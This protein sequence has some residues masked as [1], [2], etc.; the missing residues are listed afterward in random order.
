[1]R[2]NRPFPPI[3]KSPASEPIETPPR[4]GNLRR[5]A[6]SF[7]HRF[8]DV[9]LVAAGL[10]LAIA[11]IYIYNATRAP[12]QNLTQRDINSAVARALET[13]TPPPSFESKAFELIRPSLV[14]IQALNGS[15]TTAKESH[16][17]G[18]VID[19]SGGILT[20]YHVVDDATKITVVF[21]DGSQ[22]EAHVIAA[23]PE[24]DLALI[25]PEII[26]DD[27]LPA[28]LA[29]SASLRTGDEVVAVGNPFGIN[30]S[31]SSGVVSGK[32][33]NFESDEAGKTLSDLIQFDAAVNPGNSGGPLLNRDGEVVGIIAALFN[34]T[35]QNVFIGI[36]FAI[37]IDTAASVGGGA[38]P[39]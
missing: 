32:G 13:A 21:A 39:Y 31:V 16:G 38:P 1:M 11:S 33:R 20:V 24:N 35:D 4:P 5:R 26:P 36:G 3:Q 15:G 34:P 10:L 28:T 37:P 18:V 27:L 9:F 30:N 22:S 7:Y 23:Q 12:P 29:S 2:Q 8:H 19:E 6:G 17:S 14:Q 25:Q